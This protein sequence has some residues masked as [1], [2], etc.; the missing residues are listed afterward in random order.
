[1]IF[2]SIQ[3]LLWLVQA[4]VI[5]LYLNN[6]IFFRGELVDN[7]ILFAPI[8]GFISTLLIG[9]ALWFLGV[10]TFLMR[11]LFIAVLVVSAISIINARYIQYKFF[12]T[13]IF[14]WLLLGC[15]LVVIQGSF[16]PFS[17]KLFQAFPLD[18]FFYQGASILFEKENINYWQDGY[19][20]L[21]FNGDKR[22]LLLDSLWPMAY[23]EIVARP[24]VDIGFVIFNWA[25]PRDLFRLGNAWE[26][27]F[28]TLQF[29]GLFG[30]FWKVL[31]PKFISGF[32]ATTLIFGYWLQYAKDYNGWGSSACLAVI[33]SAVS[34]LIFILDKNKIERRNCFY[35]VFLCIA[36]VI[37]YPELGIPCV[38]GLFLI[39]LGN[40]LLRKELILSKSV[41]GYFIVFITGIFSFHPHII[42]FIKRQAG[43]APFMVGGEEFSARGIFRLLG[44]TRDRQT[45]V[46]N[47]STDPVNFIFEPRTI[48]DML[49]GSVGLPYIT[50]IQSALT[51]IILILIIEILFLDRI[52]RRYPNLFNTLKD[53]LLLGVS[54][55]VLNVPLIV[56]IIHKVP[57]YNLAIPISIAL[58]FLV[59][60]VMIA[61]Y[62]S[63]QNSK[64]K[65]LLALV[66]YYQLFFISMLIFKIV[67]G[68]YRVFPF[69]GVFA[70]LTFLIILASFKNKIFT[71]FA[72]L[73]AIS[74]L[75]FGF[76]IF[77]VTNTVGLEKFDSFYSLRT[78]VRHFEIENV[79]DRY[80]F[81]YTALIPDLKLCQSVFIAMPQNVDKEQRAPRFQAVSLA[82]FLE[83]NRIQHYLSM[84]YRNSS[85]LIG[86]EFH[87]GFKRE[88]VNADCVV[89]DE[90]KDGK[91]G[92]KLI[93]T[94]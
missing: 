59:L 65:L 82:L 76:S 1:M 89:E 53:K 35:I 9:S 62:F 67:G 75:V 56:L 46:G 23:N 70:S 3:I 26:V 90:L 5:G 88:E 14:L 58:G 34:Y 47:L 51:L 43:L 24:A 78:P 72:Y 12:K 25:T 30:I 22:S 86:G 21:A 48:A 18:R 45:F 93:R 37:I 74:N 28:R 31:G 60:S 8:S 38:I 33:I 87:P 77:Y 80:N 32:L 39:I 54:L 50:Y 83:N 52:I 7:V 73:I 63:S 71:I 64:I 92:Y 27:F 85:P 16:L 29:W 79:R 42:E 49:T 84:P 66:A 36:S 91:I 2:D 69:W 11:Y 20:R 40:K 13:P 6:K 17:E 4:T 61:G 57:R 19:S 15:L 44:S 10:P 68:A 81:D 41:L 55:L 94:R